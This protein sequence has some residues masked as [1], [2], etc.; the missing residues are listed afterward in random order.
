ML[1]KEIGKYKASKDSKSDQLIQVPKCDT[2]GTY[3][4]CG[5]RAS[6]AAA[7][8]VTITGF[9]FDGV[10]YSIT[11]TLVTAPATI[12]SLIN[13][14]IK[15]IEIDPV[16]EVKY[17]GVT[18]SVNHI[19]DGTL[20]SVTRSVGGAL[21]T[22]RYCIETVICS[23]EIDVEGTV[24]VVVNGTMS[25][26][27]ATNPYNYTGVPATDTATAATLKTDMEAAL[28]AVAQPFDSVTVLVD[29]TSGRYNVKVNV[30]GS[31]FTTQIGTQKF[32][33]GDC[34]SEL[35]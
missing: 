6:A 5:D 23:H 14:E 2:C 8:T 7:N 20:T 15:K 19:G 10:T 27:L 13:A 12:A 28:T 35:R 30:I 25:A 1:L 32:V 16:I 3:D 24:A 22:T 34:I 21:A 31:T 29:N 9:V 17:D 33:V 4:S 11:P 26:A 18:I